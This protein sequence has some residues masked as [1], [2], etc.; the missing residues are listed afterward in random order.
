MLENNE[1]PSTFNSAKADILF[2]SAAVILLFLGLG[3]GGLWASEDRWAEITREMLLNKDFLHPAI[4]GVVYFDKPLLSYWL[5]AGVSLIF[6]SLNE[7]IIRL[8]SALCA[9]AGLYGTIFIGR[10]LWNR[11]VGLTAGWIL[12][13]CY[14]F[15]FWGRAAAADMANL[16]AIILAVAWFFNREEKAGFFSYLL[17][18]LICFLGAMTKGLPALVMPVAIILPYV[19][20]EK[21]WKKHLKISNFA[22]AF[23]GLGFYL[24]PFYLADKLPM[25]EFYQVPADNLTGLKLV[26][27]ENIVRVFKPFDHDDEPFFCYLYQLP[28]MLVPWTLFFVAGVA[29]IAM[30]W[31]KLKPETRWL[32][33]ASILVFVLFSASGSRRWYYILPLLP[34]CAIMTSLFLA[35][36]NRMKWQTFIIALMRKL[37]F[38][39]AALG[40]VALPVIPLWSRVVNFPPPLALLLS[41]PLIGAIALLIMFMDKRGKRETLEKLS[42]IPGEVAGIILAGTVLVG[43]FFCVQLPS[44][45]IYRTEKPFALEMKKELAGI[46]AENIIFFKKES[47]KMVFYMD[48]NRPAPLANDVTELKKIL[49]VRTGKIA[50]VSYNKESSLNELQ[51]ALPAVQINKPDFIE[52]YVPYENKKARKLCVWKIN[53]PRGK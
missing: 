49:S 20:R 6:Q 39:A 8:P 28:R 37:V 31:K 13:S 12:L 46:P 24:I 32:A 23:L 33:E 10:K 35:E 4:N 52:S 45:D 27:R 51:Q 14:G 22:A 44:L 42:G 48:L 47:P 16:A 29:G 3:N 7:F 26:W 30:S 41:A 17:F 5:I 43:G 15:L 38:I 53:I 18:Y 9:L 34:F 2:W 1:Q 40:L 50:L 21:R 36:V 11:T 25:P 19:I